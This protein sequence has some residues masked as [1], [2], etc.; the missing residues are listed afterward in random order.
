MGG[1][2]FLAKA[3]QL[4]PDSIRMVLTG[5]A[6]I[7]AAMQAINQGG[8]YRYIMKPWNDDDLRITVRDALAH[9]T[10]V[11]E[12]RALNLELAEK[13]QSLSQMN[14]QLEEMVKNRTQEL[15]QKVHEL[16]GRDTI[17]QLLLSVHP[18]DELLQTVLSVVV[19]VCGL[20]TAA[21]YAVGEESALNRLAAYSKTLGKEAGIEADSILPQLQARLPQLSLAVAEGGEGQVFDDQQ[22]CYALTPVAKGETMFGV[23]L[24]KRLPGEPFTDGERASLL[25]F[26]RQAAIGIKDCQIHTNYDTIVSSLD[27]I[28]DDIKDFDENNN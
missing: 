27:G 11:A 10:L 9:F 22:G 18:L 3:A 7:N 12:N 23:L 24:A 6:D 14:E 13:N 17:Q 25:S 16:E 2:E 21:Y 28:L 1:A 15:H 8:I 5:Y 20:A 19:D 26:A 4:V